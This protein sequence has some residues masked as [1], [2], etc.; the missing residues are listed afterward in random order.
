M[1]NKFYVI[2]FITVFI[3]CN[4]SNKKNDEQKI[5]SNIKYELISKLKLNK[6]VNKIL[7]VPDNSCK[8]C[9]LETI[10]WCEKLTA[11]SNIKVYYFNEL[12]IDKND[13]AK[14]QDSINF[15]VDY[16]NYDIYGITLF[17]L[18]KDSI[19]VTYIEPSNLDSI[20]S[21]IT[22]TR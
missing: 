10:E 22:Q 21:T 7:F 9:L 5:N 17:E 14:R 15:K 8:G 11:S 16:I 19:K 18:L 3:S 20:Y 12:N 6:K 2:I 1:I 4:N 13:C